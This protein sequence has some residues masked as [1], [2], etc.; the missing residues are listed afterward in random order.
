[1][2]HSVASPDFHALEDCRTDFH[3]EESPE[4]NLAR[5]DR[6]AK[7][8]DDLKLEDRSQR[9]NAL[10]FDRTLRSQERSA[11]VRGARTG[12]VPDSSAYA[13]YSN[14]T[15]VIFAL[16]I[17]ALFVGLLS[18]FGALLRGSHI[19]L[20]ACSGLLSIGF[21]LISIASRSGDADT[22]AA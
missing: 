18:G 5:K 11:L 1:M 2:L 19:W 20:V 22:D 13:G 10:I 16:A 21:L 3:F 12:F 9:H 15:R 17:I 8:H 4:H 14:L 7:H 6:R